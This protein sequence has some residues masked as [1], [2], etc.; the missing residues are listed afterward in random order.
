M[1]EWASAY[2]TVCRENPDVIVLNLD[3]P[4]ADWRSLGASLQSS[5]STVTI[6]V[7]LLKSDAGWTMEVESLREGAAGMLHRPLEPAE[8]RA[9]L[10]N[11]LKLAV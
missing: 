7:L 1:S 5:L 9:R 11:A 6:P 3:Q 2:E 10:D 8:V 4:E